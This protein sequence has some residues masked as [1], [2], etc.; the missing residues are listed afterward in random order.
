MKVL[1][2]ALVVLALAALTGCGGGRQK[3]FQTAGHVASLIRA[4]WGSTKGSPSFDYT[5][6]GLDDRG[7]LFTCLVRDNSDT[8]R[9]ASFDV[10]CDRSKCTWT[11]YPSYSS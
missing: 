9:I 6:Q 7:R 2:I 11:D 10:V 4:K 1:G 5:C 3:P 8:V